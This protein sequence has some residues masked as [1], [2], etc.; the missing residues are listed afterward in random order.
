MIKTKI[1]L[2][3]RQSATGGHQ[4]FEFELPA[5]IDHISIRLAPIPTEPEP[6]SA[7]TPESEEFFRKCEACGKIIQVQE[8]VPTWC[9]E[10][11]VALENILPGNTD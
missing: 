5:T 2:E 9:P 3:F 4:A 8:D 10:C 6:F 11:R 7:P 1:N